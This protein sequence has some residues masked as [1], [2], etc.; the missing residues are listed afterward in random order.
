MGPD[1]ILRR[2]VM[3][4]E[5]LLILAEAH[6][7][8]ARGHYIGKKTTQKVLR[9]GLWWPTLHRDAKDYYRACDACQRVEKSSIRDEMTLEP[10]LTLQEFEKWAIDF[11]GPINPTRKSTR[12]R[13][14][15][16]VTK[17]L[18]TWAEAREVKDY[19]ATTNAHFIFDDIITRFGCPKILMS[20]Q[21][22]HFINKSVEALTDEFAVHHQKHT[23]YHPQ[24][25]GTIEAFNNILEMTLSKI[26]ILNRDDWDL[27]VPI[28]LWAYRTTCKK[29]IMQTPFK[30]VYG[31]EAVVPM[32]YLVPSLRII[33]FTDMDDIGIVKER[34]MQLI[35]LEED[36]FI[37]GFHQQVHK[38]RE[39]AYHERHTKKKEFKQGDLVLVYDSKFMNHPGKFRIHWLGPYEVSYVTEGGFA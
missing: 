23:P 7:G 4:T 2:C 9:A 19:S 30:L 3:E 35:E 6:E 29:L 16:T 11:V 25:N 31:L 1:E 17:Y 39:K 33:A 15:I 10:Q 20:D 27:S 37:V 18:T 24:A 34:L 36:I 38:K 14:I 13:Y 22:T 21:G 5:R 12:A 32:E 26:F 8:I 28:V